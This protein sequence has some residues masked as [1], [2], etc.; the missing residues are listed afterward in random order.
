MAEDAVYRLELETYPLISRMMHVGIKP[1]LPHFAALSIRLGQ[2][3][4]S[5]QT[6]LDNEAWG[7][8]NANSHTQV[9]ELLFKRYGLDPI[10]FTSTGD[11]STNDKILEALEHENPHYTSIATLREYREIH[12]LRSTFVD[13]IPAYLDRWPRD[14]RIH[15]TFRTTRV[16]TGRLAASDPNILALPKHGKFAKD[17]RRGL[18]AEPGHLLAEWDLG[19]IELRVL[20][21]LSQDP[22]LLDAFRRGIDLHSVL[23]ERIFGVA[24]N[25]QDKSKHR[26]PAKA[27]NFGLPMG[28]QATGLCLELRKNGLDV[29]EDDAQQWIDETMTLYK[30]IPV[31]Q[32]HMKAEAR[33]HGYIRCLSGRIR[34]IGGIHSP[35]EHIRAE[36]ERFA[37]STPIQ[38]GATWL[39]K[40]AEARIW[41]DLLVPCWRQGDWIEPLMQVHDAIVLEIGNKEL[42]Q[43]VH[44]LMQAIMTYPVDRFSVPI[45]VSGEWGYNLADLQEFP[46]Q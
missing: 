35:H 17:F 38:E 44:P 21:H 37:F 13:A 26:L 40:M 33:R 15:S 18:I 16:V 23:A 31:Y 41:R 42:A 25:N 6:I 36:A 46:C 34:Y 27:I 22:T 39:M 5:L 11:P 43:D 10:K 2:E 8:F 32:D 7:G 14:G 24:A 45:E 28:M 29:D 19:Q 12:K 4:E 30:E 9:G 1:D 3:L 20:A